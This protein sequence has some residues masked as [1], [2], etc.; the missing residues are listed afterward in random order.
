VR[1]EGR[2]SRVSEEQ[3]GGSRYAVL[4]SA[5]GDGGENEMIGGRKEESGVMSEPRSRVVAE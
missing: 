3:L 5:T 1:G 2:V 4:G